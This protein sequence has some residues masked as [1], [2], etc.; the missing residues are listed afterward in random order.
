MCVH[1]M[2]KTGKRRERRKEKSGIDSLIN[3]SEEK[4]LKKTVLTI[5]KTARKTLIRIIANVTRALQQGTEIR[6]NFSDS[7]NEPRSRFE[8]W[9]VHED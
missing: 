6:L 8:S 7:N 1:L 9:C 2:G 4:L 3:S 5:I